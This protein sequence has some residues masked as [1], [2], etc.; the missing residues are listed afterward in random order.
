MGIRTVA[1]YS[2]L[3]AQSLH[4]RLADEAVCIGKRS[5]THEESVYLSIPRI[6]DA[7]RQTGAEA[8]H[9]G[10]G[11]LSEN[12]SFVQQLEEKGII[13]VGPKASAIAAMGDKIQ[14]KLIAK[15]SGVYCIPGFDREVKTV[16]EA[17][18][19]AHEIGYPVMI[20]ASAGGGGKGM[21]IAWNDEEMKDGF[22]LAKQESRSSF[23]DDRMLIEK[24]I[25]NPRHIEI[26]ILGDNHG[27]VIYLPER[28]C[29]IQR[30]NQKV[31]EESPSVHMTETIRRRMGEQAVALAKGVGYNSAGT[32]EFLV[33]SQR[34]FYFLEMNTRLQVEH[35]VTEYVTGLDLVEHMLYSAADYPLNIQ[36]DSITINGWA[37]EARVYAEDSVNYLPSVGRLR[38][39]REPSVHPEQ[40]QE[41]ITNAKGI[42]C[43]SG[44]IEGSEIHVDYDP[45]ICKLTTHGNTRSEALQLMLQALDQYVIKGVTHNIPLLR[46]VFAHPRFQDGERITTHFL[47]EE[48]PNGFKTENLS[49]QTLGD[50]ASVQNIFQQQ[51]TPAP[52][53]NNIN[54]EVKKLWIQVIDEQDKSMQETS[55]DIKSLGNSR[56]KAITSGAELTLSTQW[57]IDSVLAR[58]KIFIDRLDNSSRS[59]VL[60]Y[61]DPSKLGF[62]IQFHGNKYQINVLTDEQHDLKKYMRE[63]SKVEQSK[64]V[65]SP[66][67]G[68]IVSLAVEEGDKVLQG[69]EL[70]VVEAMKMQNI[71]RASQSGVIKKIHFGYTLRTSL[72]PEWTCYYVAYDELK[73][74]LKKIT[75]HGG[76]WS[77]ESESL[78]IER[79]EAELDK[80]Y[81]FQRAKL[82]EIKHRIEQE[83]LEVG[84]LC[85][86]DFPDEDDFTASEIEL[87]HIIA[88]VHDLAK[89]VK[90]NYTGFLKIIKKHDKVT[91]WPLKPMFGVRLNA[92]PFHK[93]NYD[94]LIIRISDLYDRVRTRGQER[95]GDSGAGGK[96]SAFV[97]NTTKYWVHP[98]NITEL[99]LAIL[100]H[101]PVLVFNP[102]KEFETQDSAIS[103]V[104]F[105]NDDFDLYM[106]RLEKSEGAQAIRMRWYG[107]MGSNTIF[108]ERKTHHEDWTGEKSVKARFPIKE[109]YLNSFLA[110][111]YTTDELF[112]KMKEQGKKLEKEIQELEQLAQ[113]VQ[114][115]VLTKRLHPMM[116]TFYNR[117]AFQLPGDA[118][119]RI[120]L[121]TELSLIRE[122]NMD[123]CIRSGGNW[124]RM[125]IGIDYPFK[126]LPDSDICRFPY[127]ILEVKLQ[128]HVGQEPPQWVLELV[129]S[130]LVESVPKFSKFIHGCATLMED[131]IDTLP[132]WLPQMGI[133]IRK[134][135][136][137]FFGIYRPNAPS[138]SS[139]SGSSGS[140]Y[141]ASKLSAEDQ[142]NKI[143]I[144]DATETTP[145]LIIHNNNKE[146][147]IEQLM[148]SAGMTNLFKRKYNER[149]CIIKVNGQT[150]VKS[151]TAR[152]IL[153]KPPPA[154]TYFAN[155]RTFLHW[156]KFTLLL[157]GLAIGLLNFSDKIGRLSASIF[158]ALSMSVM[159]Y[160]LYHYHNRVSRVNKN[161]LGD[162]SDK[163][164][165]AVLTLLVIFAIS[166]N[167][168]LRITMDFKKEWKI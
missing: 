155:E 154:K 163:Y 40:T 21:R 156:L 157:G 34:R 78:F 64:L 166:I 75:T 80:V 124:R 91:G 162:F 116:R 9:P 22:K 29:S 161:E 92:K 58:A 84:R 164:G 14:S 39:Y 137:T 112:A 26:Q 123:H 67:P 71:L 42:R 101:L 45:L 121:D 38:T 8:V 141:D 60:Q 94:A 72:N 82:D 167:V 74:I 3:D 111:T 69:S 65:T 128:T 81:T 87:G 148:T 27:N 52:I 88:D 165:P 152:P 10:Y 79:L 118:R 25:D 119:V 133:D 102:N 16:E 99:K 144:R 149:A 158:T 63:E 135:R 4:V 17:I 13:F 96:Q 24:Y 61:L 68:R 147:F 126:Q 104:Y 41:K 142:H 93:E 1:V 136:S 150:M 83:A 57:P 51:Y 103:S 159:I 20:K 44:F 168:Y 73:I 89:F 28:E 77:E 59:L 33:D 117:T 47:A 48:Y 49:Q 66:M 97:R 125:D 46:A 98:D 31:I 2:D 110:G 86:S 139:V 95:C 114:Y 55:V 43:D 6:M 113:E 105:D 143:T 70:I 90:L 19:M 131:K 146:G 54:K 5:N 160:A 56:F 129:N 76:I 107:G 109:K 100:K 18:S 62:R 145:L 132:F 138:N 130:H 36:Q 53:V 151:R 153:L 115:T 140:V 85:Q 30:R 37:M 35:P 15:K 11:F 120:S 122:D 127:A 106:G 12:A 32:V 23:G 134:P 108:V 7:I 50:L